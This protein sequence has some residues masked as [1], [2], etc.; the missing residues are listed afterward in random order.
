VVLADKFSL[1]L[2]DAFEFDASPCFKRYSGVPIAP[3]VPVREV[4]SV[5]IPAATDSTT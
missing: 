3:P 5:T 1:D 4:N 2:S